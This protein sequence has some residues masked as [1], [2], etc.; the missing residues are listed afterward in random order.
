MLL[1]FKVVPAGA[2]A[3]GE[4]QSPHWIRGLNTIKREFRSPANIW[5]AAE[6][7]E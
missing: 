1:P 3:A 7:D 5:M 6:S 2:A 4:F